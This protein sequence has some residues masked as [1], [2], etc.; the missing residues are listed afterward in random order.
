MTR[1]K[2]TAHE[3]AQQLRT[4]PFEEVDALIM[5]YAEDTR[6]HVQHAVAVARRRHE[7]EAAD[8]ARVRAMYELQHELGGEGIIIGV[9][10]VGRGALA[11]P[12]TVAA[13]VL[14][15]DPMVWGI[16][17][18]KQL[19][20]KQRETLAVQ[21]RACARAIGIAQ[22]APES[23]DQ[24]GMAASLRQA[25]AEAIADTGV[26]AD[27]V[28]IDGNPIHAHPKERMLVKG[29]AR[30]AAIAA[31]SIVAKV[32]RDHLMV[33]YDEIYPAYHLALSKGY[34][35]VEHI[36]AIKRYGLT[37]IHRKSF[38]GNF[39]EPPSLL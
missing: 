17:D 26:D 1:Y 29:D 25:M 27:C 24:H 7:H 9:D 39:M 30:I 11:G 18:S 8:R 13:V 19:T 14:P 12:L 16:N 2:Q 28:F 37:P 35:S 22:I 23:I 36:A 34:G 33:D 3:I 6:S 10:E 15:D 20:P 32:T 4:A 21:I 31:A 5:R 38:C